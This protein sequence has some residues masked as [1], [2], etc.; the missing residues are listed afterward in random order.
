MKTLAILTLAAAVTATDHG[1]SYGGTGPY[2]SYYFEVES[3]ANHSF[4]QPL[5][6]AAGSNL[7]LPVIVWGN[8]GFGLT[9]RGFLG[10]VASHGALAIAT[11]PAYV[12]PETY[13]P[14]PSDPSVGASG[15]N[16]AVMTAA[17]DWVHANAG[18]GDW[19]HVDASR[20]GVWGQSCGGLEAY[21]AGLSDPR[22][23]H[24]G[25][26]NSGQLNETASNTVAGNLTKP[27]FY[28]LGGPDDVAYPNGERDYSLLPAGTPAWKGNHALGHSAAF[29][30]PNG[31]IPAI[32]GSHILEWILR[33]NASAKDWFTGDGPE[34][35]GV[36]DVVSKDLDSIQVT[37]IYRDAEITDQGESDPG[38]SSE[39][40]LTLNIWRS[41]DADT[42]NGTLPVL[43]WLY[44]GGLTNGFTADPRF[45]GTSITKISKQLEKPI[46]LVSINYRLGPFGFLNGKEM[47]ELG[48]LN[49]GMLDQRLAL[50]WLQENIGAFG[51]DPKKVT[52]A[53]ESAGAV[54]IY[55]HMMA[56]GGRDDGL[57]RGAILESGGAFPLTLPDTASFQSTF[58][59]LL[60][61]TNCSSLVT[62]GA[63][64]K[65]ACIRTLPVDVF[66][67]NVGSST[68]QSV[69]GDF[70]RTSIQ[71][72][73]PDGKYL[74]VAT[75]VG[76]NTDEGTT[77]A[78][79]GINTTEQL[80][81][82]V[83]KGYFR[84]QPLPN[85]T[86]STLIKMYSTK[87]SLGC[88]YNTGTAQFSSGVLDKMACSIFG[89]IV[90]IGPARMIAQTLARDGV[91]VYRYRFNHLSYNSSSF[92]KGIGTGVEQEYVFSNVASNNPW[93][94]NMAYQ[95][96]AA[97]I[98][99]AHDLDPNTAIADTGLP[100][101]PRYGKEANSMVLNGFGSWIERDTDR[102]DAVQYIIDNVLPDGAL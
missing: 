64:E 19:K 12:D 32:V 37:P 100:S 2:K 23:S 18:K 51:G 87:P 46:V 48:L 85:D 7:K 44:G 65:L 96:S 74:K 41:A 57:F 91:P 98:S 38:N 83:S 92:S 72:A 68:G 49:I 71:R 33:G 73:L 58:D 45:E 54:S 63:E 70:S 27:V 84:P 101:W 79:T 16:P 94:R 89:D 42:S 28:T 50:H 8:G 80:F 88:P 22:V 14:P 9:F 13:V 10:E 95:M 60:S 34:S 102:S 35:I 66:R 76:T 67:A 6:S 25:I 56:Y 39:D 77:S 69:D 99:F 47:A 43:V 24:I 55:S 40:C 52:L 86:V 97:W 53:G 78:P 3:L 31:G 90:Q 93:D 62:A 36:I 17:I 81:D 82:P 20:I 5:E 61:K 29:D 1:P 30:A 11:G 59:S 26:F 75:I 4:Y 21:T 15:Q